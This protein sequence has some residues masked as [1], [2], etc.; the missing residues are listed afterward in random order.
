VIPA[1]FYTLRLSGPGACTELPYFELKGPGENI[2][3]NM[4]L[5]EMQAIDIADFS[6]SSTYT[7]RSDAIPGVVYTFMTSAEVEGTRP[8]VSSGPVRTPSGSRPTVS[9]HDVVGSALFP[10]RGTLIGGVS[11]AGR[12]TFAYKG[13]SI[14]SL[15]AGRYTITV[16]DKS[17][18][19]GF[20][21][22]KAKTK[23][24]TVSV[25]G[26]A[27]VGTRS[28]SVDLTA[29]KWLF[30][31]ILHGKQTYSIVVS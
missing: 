9:S 14:T 16:H 15:K 2:L 24:V 10:F 28:A 30:L 25:T 27:F 20:M 13:K 22:E 4:D 1:G 8:P 12:L 23:H 7:W 3:D 6:P 31:P 18:A 11:A 17:A 29:G 26:A 21:L 19:S 5:G